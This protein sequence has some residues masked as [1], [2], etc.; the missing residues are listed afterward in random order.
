MSNSAEVAIAGE[1]KSPSPSLTEAQLSAF[2]AGILSH[3]DAARR[4]AGRFVAR[5]SVDD[6]VHTAA[7][8]FVESLEPPKRAPFPKTDDEFRRRFL[9]IVRNHAINCIHDSHASG[10]PIHSHWGVETEPMVGGHH[11]A[12][13][14][15]DRVFARNDDAKYDAPASAELRAQDTTDQLDYLLRSCVEDLPPQQQKIINETFFEKR[16]RAEV[17]RRL[18]IS[19]STYDNHLQAAFR[20]LRDQLAQ[21]VELFTDVDRSL[22]Y[23]FIEDLCERYE[24]SILRRACAK[25]GKRPTSKGDRSNFEGDRSNSEHDRG[26]NSRA[27]AA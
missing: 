25:K 5:E 15:L 24:A 17:A 4:M 12:D 23:D 9:V 21:V 26:K 11:V 13:R 2:W 18:G 19:E 1:R 8:H 27:G 22:W 20:S 7:S 3:T 14:E 10:R 16:K 6:I